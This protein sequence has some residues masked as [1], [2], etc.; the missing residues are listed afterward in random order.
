MNEIRGTLFS[1]RAI[2]P[3]ATNPNYVVL[4]VT[5]SLE[6]HTPV[7][8]EA[9]VPWLLAPLEVAARWASIAEVTG[10][11]AE[12][13]G[14]SWTTTGNVLAAEAAARLNKLSGLAFDVVLGEPGSGQF[15][16]G[17]RFTLVPVTPPAAV[18]VVYEEFSHV[19]VEPEGLTLYTIPSLP[20]AS[21]STGSAEDTEPPTPVARFVWEPPR[22][23]NEPEGWWVVD[24]LAWSDAHAIS[25]A[26]SEATNKRLTEAAARLNQRLAGL[27]VPLVCAPD[28]PP[29]A[30]GVFDLQRFRTAAVQLL[31]Q[32]GMSPIV[33]IYSRPA[34]AILD[35]A[36][37]FLRDGFD[38]HIYRYQAT[39]GVTFG[40][41]ALARDIGGQVGLQVLNKVP[42]IR[43]ALQRVIEFRGK[44]G[45]VLIPP[46]DTCEVMLS[47]VD[48]A[49]PVITSVV[50]MPYLTKA[51]RMNC[52]PGYD[53][54]SRLMY[55]PS[56]ANMNVPADPSATELRQAVLDLQT[57]FLQF[58]FADRASQAGLYMM[59]FEQFVAPIIEGPRPLYAIGAPPF[60][61]SSGKTLLAQTVGV[62]LT[63]STE[64]V[65]AWPD[66]P[67]DLP[68]RIADHLLVNDAFVA[69]DNLRGLVNSKDLATL[70]TST[71]WTHRL[72]Y[73]D[74]SLKLPNT[75]TWALT[76]NGAKFDRDLARRTV[77]IRLDAGMLDAFA[78]TEFTIKPLA[79]WVKVNRGR[80][81]KAIIT[82]VSAWLAK[83]RP[84]VDVS[85]SSFES[86][87][88]AV[89]P[90][91]ATMGYTPDD[92]KT[93]LGAAKS[94]DEET[95][96]IVELIQQW[97]ATYTSE[98]VNAT[99][100]VEL[101]KEHG[102]FARV[103]RGDARWAAR[104]M[105]VLLKD[106]QGRSIDGYDIVSLQT[107][108][109]LRLRK[110]ADS[111][112]VN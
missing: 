95:T 49:L 110:S 2:T 88:Q 71:H 46:T 33:H 18:Q 56:L 20:S 76:L 23:F 112:E 68:R 53:A 74:G 72:V 102:L 28:A 10:L 57:P 89:L 12:T 61:Q 8:W 81:V 42:A 40:Y 58:P 6:D 19:A 29:N 31:K 62:I 43:G 39:P 50:R 22:Y 36:R 26:W 1:A 37:A 17:G 4:Q 16:D 87:A 55:A 99:K 32:S 52:T 48:P 80:L 51:G 73:T 54:E 66:D 86:W 14:S 109:Q 105:S 108:F 69:F 84:T 103:T 27:R 59:L 94:K 13:M 91:V 30:P 11:S 75:T 82:I 79:Q 77:M 64:C 107:G 3:N 101:A 9:Q 90:L 85:F 45:K 111:T 93:A 97:A 44:N 35:R 100:L 98:T 83:G 65:T 21:G 60:G 104:N 92:I 67:K 41:Y 63:G 7:V 15:P 96:E 78:R 25:E 70:I 106:L 5:F 47:M 38:G 34:K 24:G